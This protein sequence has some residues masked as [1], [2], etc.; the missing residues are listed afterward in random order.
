[1]ALVT[2]AAIAG[3]AVAGPG[4]EVN[5][6]ASTKKTAKRALKLAK[7]NKAAIEDVEAGPQGEK[8]DAG[9]PGDAGADGED[10]TAG[11]A[12]VLGDGSVS[13]SSN[14]GVTNV[15][16]RVDVG[17]SPLAGQYCFH[18]LSF[19]PKSIQATV[20]PET[21]AG[22]DDSDVVASDRIVSATIGGGPGCPAGTAATATILDQ[23]DGGGVDQGFN[24]WFED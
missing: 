23:S 21:L 1:M 20:A 18:A 13:E 4:P 10:G 8:G 3:S 14:V 2:A 12:H 9:I 16:K 15:A 6:S 7:K 24:V 17:L 5:G 19:T 11:Y 22:Q